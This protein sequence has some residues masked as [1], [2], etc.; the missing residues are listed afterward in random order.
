MKNIMEMQRM[1]KAAKEMQDRLQKE[2]AEMRVEGSSGG[3]MVTVVLDG[4]KS[5][6][7]VRIDPEVVSKDDVDMLQDLVLAAL[8]DAA[9]KVDARMEERLGALG[10]NLKIPGMF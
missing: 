5:P 8:T 9:A 4:K 7:S 6:V 10:A 2:L 3:G 1:L